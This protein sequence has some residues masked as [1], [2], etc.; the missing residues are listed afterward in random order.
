MLQS[1][2]EKKKHNNALPYFFVYVFVCVSV[3]VSVCIY[4]LVN[5]YTCNIVYDLPLTYHN[6]SEK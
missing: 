2:Y 6:K 4:F 1:R 3:R 5:L